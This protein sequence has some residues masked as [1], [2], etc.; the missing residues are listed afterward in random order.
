MTTS[1]TPTASRPSALP[2]LTSPS[3]ALQST[4]FSTWYPN[5]R[6][7]SPKATIIDL[8][9]VQPE[10]LK[11]LEEDGIV[12]PE[13]SDLPIGR[14]GE[15]QTTRRPTDA[16]DEDDA[17]DVRPAKFDR[18]DARIRDVIKSYDGAVF[19]KLNWSAPLDAA[20]IVAGSTLRC[21]T[22]ADVYLL[23]KSSDFVA[24]DTEQAKLLYD[25]QSTAGKSAVAISSTDSHREDTSAP[26]AQDELEIA[27][28]SSGGATLEPMKN[29]PAGLVLKKWFDM[30]PSHE[31]RCF[32]RAANLI[33]ISQRDNVFYSHLQD[34]STQQTIRAQLVD[35]Y[36]TYLRPRTPPPGAKKGRDAGFSVQDFV[37]DA[38]LTRNM[39]RVF[40]VDVGPYLPRTDSL[41]WTWEELE[42]EAARI[43]GEQGHRIAQASR[44][45]PAQPELRLISSEGQA[46]QSAPTHVRNMV[47]RDVLQH[48]DGK[49]IVEFAREWEE[50][51]R[52]AVLEGEGKGARETN[53]LQASMQQ[54][55]EKQSGPEAPP[56]EEAGERPSAATDRQVRFDG[57]DASD[58][59][60]EKA[61]TDNE[62]DAAERGEGTSIG[63]AGFFAALG[64]LDDG[65]SGEGEDS[66]RK[67]TARRKKKRKSKEGTNASND[68][69]AAEATTAPGIG[70][71]Q[72]TKPASGAGKTGPQ[73]QAQRKAKK[74]SNG[75]ASGSSKAKAD[76]EK[77]LGNMSMDEFTELLASQAKL[78]GRSSELSGDAVGSS[79]S[80]EA[81][82]SFSN[83]H[84]SS[85][86]SLLA[87]SASFL[88]PTVELKRQ[89]GAAA[90]R[91]YEAE[92]AASGNNTAGGAASRRAQ[93]NW[94]S[95]SR[96]R[97]TLVQPPDTWPPISRTFTGMNM[98]TLTSERGRMGAW[99]H[100]RAYRQVQLAFLQAVQSYDPN[101][102]VALLRQ[103]PWHVD[104]L[105]QL[106]DISR[107]QGDL[108]QASDFNARALFAYERTA[109]PIF[110][111][112]L[113][114][115]SGPP[116]VDFAK[117]ENR[118][119]WLA[120]HRQINFLC[121]KGTWRTALEWTK[122][123][124]GLDPLED[125]HA[126]V[127]WI[128]FIAVK[129]RQYGWFVEMLDQLDAS[130]AKLLQAQGK[131]KELRV[132]LNP[133][134]QKLWKE[135]GLAQ[136]PWSAL[137]WTVG[138]YYAR[139][140][141]VRAIEK[142]EG[143]QESE[144]SSAALKLAIA[145]CPVF[146]TMLFDKIGNAL[147][148][149]LAGSNLFRIDEDRYSASEDALA[150]LLGNIYV[151]R[152][153]S[154]WREPATNQWLL[155]TLEEIWPEL[156]KS[157]NKPRPL[158]C[159]DTHRRAVYRH[160]L[161][162]DLPDALRQKLIGY[163]PPEITNKESLD[164]WDP[165]PPKGP[166]ATCYDDEYFAPVQRERERQMRAS[167]LASNVAG[168]A[169]GGGLA[170][171]LQNLVNMMRGGGGGLE[172]WGAAMEQMDD[173]TREDLMAELMQMTAEARRNRGVAADEPPG[174]FGQAA[175]EDGEEG[176][177]MFAEAEEGDDAD[178]GPIGMLR[179]ALRGWWG[180]DQAQAQ[181]DTLGEEEAE[182]HD[183]ENA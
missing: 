98:E 47:P 87:L 104:T 57:V 79:T 99:I 162:S 60:S 101:Q 182:Q 78:S 133:L 100:S 178:M 44:S 29:V 115:S 6:K 37:F 123:I 169:G 41:L 149:S 183:A 180:G 59:E 38:Y 21:T 137:D 30:P 18:L 24:N 54:Q 151:A 58:E 34:V 116:Q 120:V 117:V 96:F 83:T 106:S 64:G 172:E 77:T 131:A 2:A 93:T 174:A 122:F 74:P 52:G 134:E 80:Q 84:L 10:F 158:Q 154:L 73:P 76:G 102:L 70:T 136:E 75:R 65:T 132:K 130:N 111:S 166:H 17:E 127:L 129:A 23:L 144:R 107:H 50:S 33:G 81:D 94:N 157:E 16:Q 15:Q 48:S 12:L 7:I 91:A 53:T 5:F 155:D 114:S 145:R 125:P 95:N 175:D 27:T 49:S 164:A 69:D 61:E 97:N 103:C 152:S 45:P 126:S 142:D 167:G 177:E 140:L 92:M 46:S 124:L 112:G 3:Q 4:L 108:G 85:L 143:R 31:Y 179:N 66:L 63:Q 51:L 89:F 118:G 42:S 171:A 150:L 11:W 71:D 148:Q 168:A 62:E 170:N 55:G 128:D 14:E 113:V 39:D 156:Q 173:E 119:L 141:A 1:S 67:K 35:F 109:S 82:A 147:P 72:V 161:V 160:V 13:G 9:E 88:D 20:W 181:A 159:S 135:A 165:L 22:P 121:R 36:E 26:A 8:Q 153:E 86:R 28:M 105:L 40:L 90:V 25:A 138:L 32:V 163:F 56:L 139:A 43:H 176:D 110:T 146:V 19:P 68:A